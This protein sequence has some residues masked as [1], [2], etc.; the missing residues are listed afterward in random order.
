MATLINRRM[1]WAVNNKVIP[2]V[3]VGHDLAT[4]RVT[5]LL[6]NGAQHQ[7]DAYDVLATKAGAFNRLREIEKARAL[8]NHMCKMYPNLI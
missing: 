8:G 5:V 4:A 1:F 6:D 7:T 2:C 3:V